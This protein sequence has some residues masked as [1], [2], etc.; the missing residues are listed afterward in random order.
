[1]RAEV[2]GGSSMQHV[3]AGV[4]PIPR[5][6]EYLSN[7]TRCTFVSISKQLFVRALL[8]VLKTTACSVDVPLRPSAPTQ[9]THTL[10]YILS[11][12]GKNS[13]VHK[14]RVTLAVDLAREKED[15]A[16]RELKRA[17]TAAKL[18]EQQGMMTVDDTSESA[19]AA[20]A[21]VE[22][23]ASAF[24]F[25]AT[26]V[27]GGSTSTANGQTVP[28][29]TKLFGKVAI[30]SKVALGK[31]KKKLKGTAA[32]PGSA[33]VRAG[34]VSKKSRGIKKPSAIM[35]KTLKKMAKK[36]EMEMG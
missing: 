10:H 13:N 8:V 12:M 19:A 4:Y 20:S 1:M 2:A 11:T 14:R 25:T 29:K 30:G 28:R 18:A 23:A 22:A 5:R 7:V 3:R 33:P 24:T 17:R 36:R 27:P 6:P 35:R 15:D 34:L 26:S 21:A 32:D 16:K 31:K 9:Q